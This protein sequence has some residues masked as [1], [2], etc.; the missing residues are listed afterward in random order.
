[1]KSRFVNSK[2]RFDPAFLRSKLSVNSKF[3]SKNARERERE[4]ERIMRGKN[5]NKEYKSH[6]IPRKAVILKQQSLIVI[7]VIFKNRI[8]TKITPFVIH[9]VSRYH[10]LRDS[11]S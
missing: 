10:R 1:M 3:I 11:L 7:L 8:F 4:R 9:I 6:L 2:S 5:N